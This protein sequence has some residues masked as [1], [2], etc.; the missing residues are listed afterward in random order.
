[1]T[2]H[3]HTHV[4]EMKLQPLP[5]CLAPSPEQRARLE[6][7]D[8]P[9]PQVGEMVVFEENRVSWLIPNDPTRPMEKRNTLLICAARRGQ[10]C[11][12]GAD[13]DKVE[14]VSPWDLEMEESSVVSVGRARLLFLRHAKATATTETES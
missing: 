3:P 1:M 13:W 6:A 8:I 9:V 11:C 4:D 12:D 14:A 7:D 10:G 5:E 2:A